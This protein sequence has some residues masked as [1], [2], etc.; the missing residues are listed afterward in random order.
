MVWLLSSK[1]S[2]LGPKPLFRLHRQM[3]YDLPWLAFYR[4]HHQSPGIIVTAATFLHTVFAVVVSREECSLHLAVQR[5]PPLAFFD[6][7]SALELSKDIGF[8]S[9]DVLVFIYAD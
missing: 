6:L 2:S 5:Y 3:Q 1:I 9:F 4:S 7:C 8:F